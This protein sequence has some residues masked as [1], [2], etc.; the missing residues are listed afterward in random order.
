MSFREYKSDIASFCNIITRAYYLN[1][2]EKY[3]LNQLSQDE[4]NLSI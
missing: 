1:E 2:L 3:E 4:F